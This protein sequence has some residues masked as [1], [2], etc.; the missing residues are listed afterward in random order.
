MAGTGQIT[1]PTAKQEEDGPE[2][3]QGQCQLTDGREMDSQ[4]N[5]D[6]AQTDPSNSWVRVK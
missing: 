4:H 3:Q 2:T 6:A 5:G 1:P